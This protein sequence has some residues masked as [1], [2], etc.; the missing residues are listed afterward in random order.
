MVR[1]VFEIG[2]VELIG[3]KIDLVA[4][5]YFQWFFESGWD[6]LID[7]IVVFVGEF[8]LL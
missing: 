5:K 1:I 8:N 2:F 6:L 3:L 4:L 7:E